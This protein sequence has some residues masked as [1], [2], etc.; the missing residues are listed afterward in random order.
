[1]TYHGAG[2]MALNWT[3]IGESLVRVEPLLRFVHGLTFFVLGFVL[4][5]LAPRAARIE[6]ARRLPL[7]AVFGFCEAI[8]AW[9]GALAPSLEMDWLVPPLVRAFLLGAGYISLLAFGLL[10]PVSAGQ[11]LQARVGLTIVLGSSWLLGLLALPPLG[12]LTAQVAAWGEVLARCGFALP[13]GI[14]AA[15]GLRQQAHRTMDVQVLRVVKGPLQA[16]GATLAAFGVLSGLQVVA[17]LIS[18]PSS[19]LYAACGVGLTLSIVRALNVVQHEIERWIEGVEQSQALLADRERISRELHDGIIQGIYA[20][21]LMLEGVTHT[22]AEDPAAAQEQLSRAMVSL[23]QTIQDIRRYIF[24]LRGEVPEADLG[25]GLERLL[26][27]FRVNTLLEAELIVTGEEA[28]PLTSEQRGHI[29]QI[30]REAFSNIARHARAR[31]VEV[32]LSFKTDALHLHITDDGVGLSHGTV[33]G[34]HGLRNIHERVRL[35]DGELDIDSAP[36]RGVTM[37]LTVP[38]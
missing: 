24:N 36:G 28:H 12:L 1:M 16:A 37:T 5:L 23:N 21:G 15:W 3:A 18:F 20:A 11:G 9:D 22:L 26:R 29:F 2:G 8:A 27:D 7:L 35:L 30:A 19:I 17:D 33:R 32:Q 31:K 14:L 25:S 10:A 38:Y 6:I 13:G 4:L 34:G